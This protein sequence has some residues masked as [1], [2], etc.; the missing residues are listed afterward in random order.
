M[1]RQEAEARR[2]EQERLRR[3][4][5]HRWKK[6][7]SRRVDLEEQAERWTRSQ[8]LAAYIKEVEQHAARPL[9]SPATVRAIG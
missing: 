5:E 3:E 6:E 8:Q 4:E 9:V 2:L 1:R 7:E